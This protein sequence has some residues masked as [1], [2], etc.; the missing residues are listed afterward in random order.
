MST[1]KAFQKSSTHAPS[2]AAA[3]FHQLMPLFHLAHDTSVTGAESKVSTLDIH[4]IYTIKQLD[5]MKELCD[6]LLNPY[7][8]LACALFSVL[9]KCTDK[10]IKAKSALEGLQVHQ[11]K[12]TWLSQLMGVSVPCF[13]NSS[14]FEAMADG[15]T[16]QEAFTKA[17]TDFKEYCLEKAICMKTQELKLLQD[18]IHP[19]VWLNKLN[20]TCQKVYKHSPVKVIIYNVDPASAVICSQVRHDLVYIRHG[21]ICIVNAKEAVSKNITNKKTEFKKAANE[22]LGDEGNQEMHDTTPGA[23]PST[24]PSKKD[25]KKMIATVITKEKAKDLGLKTSKHGLCTPKKPQANLGKGAPPLKGPSQKPLNPPKGGSSGGQTSKAG[26]CKA[27]TQ[28]AN[29]AKK[30]RKN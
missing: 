16:Y 26:K 15:N 3:A 23:G 6:V 25:I 22:A 10:A 2:P 21:V 12:K 28:A 30:S 13:Q 24:S 9:F 27:L 17:M 14:E 19:K 7:Q 11:A 18:M 20:K 4:W 1:S 5:S 29:T 8:E